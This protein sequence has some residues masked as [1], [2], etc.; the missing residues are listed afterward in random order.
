MRLTCFSEGVR[1]H[2]EKLRWQTH[3]NAAVLIQCTW[4]SWRTRRKW[5]GN[6]RVMQ[7]QQLSNPIVQCTCVVYKTYSHGLRFL[8]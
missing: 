1:Q 3:H 6:K 5:P 4:R 8:L 7:M 2:L